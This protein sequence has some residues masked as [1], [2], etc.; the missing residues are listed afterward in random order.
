MS[1]STSKDSQLKLEAGFSFGGPLDRIL[2]GLIE[3]PQTQEGSDRYW[4]LEAL[5]ESLS[6]IGVSNPN[7]AVG[8]VIV[9]LKGR[10]VSRG[11]TQAYPGLH[12]ERVAFQG[13]K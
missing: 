2:P 10:E 8:C 5:R 6:G 11:A 12:A 13:V 3:P 9:D 4:M 1:K 7:P